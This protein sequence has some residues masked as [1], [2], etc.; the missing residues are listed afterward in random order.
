MVLGWHAELGR[1]KMRLE[2]KIK[3][4]LMHTGTEDGRWMKLTQNCV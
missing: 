1:S 2:D 4:V 3:K